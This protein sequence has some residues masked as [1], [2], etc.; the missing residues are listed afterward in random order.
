MFKGLAFM[1]WNRRLDDNYRTVNLSAVCLG[2]V[3]ALGITLVAC[4]ASGLWVLLSSAG[5]Y[6]F[7]WVLGGASLSG[8]LAGGLVAGAKVKN[9][10][11]LH[12]G[13]V[14]FCYGLI[15]VLLATEGGPGAFGSLDL[16][17]RLGIY[18][19]TGLT[20]GIIGV[21]L[22]S[23]MPVYNRHGKP[24]V[25]QTKLHKQTSIF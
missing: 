14:G 11:W 21:N 7:T 19:L 4:L 25:R 18:I 12:G 3:W 16:A 9:L 10:G 22:S 17:G 8:T 23:L 24:A 6:Y 15:F 13:L 2:L 5:I 20:A 1:Y